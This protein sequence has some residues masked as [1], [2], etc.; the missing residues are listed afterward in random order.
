[1]KN[2]CRF[3]ENKDCEYYP[4]HKDIEDINC[5]FCFC[6][7]YNL[8]HCPGKPSYKVKDGKKI[9]ICTDCTFPHQADNYD[10]IMSI[11]KR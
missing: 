6:P 5:L 2:S 1:M 8:E 4:C 7:M 3:F 10:L 9:K 11:L